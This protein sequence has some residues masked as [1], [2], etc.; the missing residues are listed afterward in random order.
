MVVAL[1]IRYRLG[2]G[3]FDGRDPA[4]PP[5]DAA[6]PGINFADARDGRDI[7]DER[8]PDT[9]PRHGRERRDEQREEIEHHAGRVE[10]V[11]EGVVD[12]LPQQPYRVEIE[13]DRRHAEQRRESTLDALFEVPAVEHC[14][15]AGDD[16]GDQ[17]QP[18]QLSQRRGEVCRLNEALEDH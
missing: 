12:D 9:A 1:H 13:R 3:E 10:G 14:H 15:R 5:D 8:V 4:E 17:R 2:L 11:S 6:D 18:K 7:A 16:E